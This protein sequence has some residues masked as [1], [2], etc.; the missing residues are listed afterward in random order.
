MI[1]N[2]EEFL[3]SRKRFLRELKDM[4]FIYPTD[5]VYGI[6]C[7]ATNEKLVAKIRELK[8]S[9]VQPFSIIAPSKQ[10]V[11]DNCV[12]N[13][14]EKEFVEQLGKHLMI[15]NAEHRFT[16][17]LRLKNKD[18]VARNVNPGKDTIGVRIPNN[19][20]SEIVADLNT[21]IITTSAN[22]TGSDFM[23]SI[24]NLHHEI[25]NGVNLIIYEG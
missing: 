11:Y 20:F 17:I 21:P 5:T 18:S 15:G 6:G 3:K 2:K 7:D 13:E 1:V 10:W 9:S 4:V 16:L 8:G 24:D 23:T 19:W 14:K 12:V 25:K 22:K